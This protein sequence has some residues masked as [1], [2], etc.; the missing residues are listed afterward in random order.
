[1]SAADNQLI[2]MLSTLASLSL[3]GRSLVGRSLVGRSLVG[4]SLGLGLLVARLV[5]RRAAAERPDLFLGA[6]LPARVLA[7]VEVEVLL[8][9]SDR[10][11]VLV[12]LLVHEPEVPPC[13]SV[14]RV[15]RGRLL[16]LG[17]RL[18]D[19]VRVLLGLPAVHHREV[20]V[21]ARVVGPPLERL[22]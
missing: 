7:L 20:E 16:V 22:S 19:H 4:R 18:R 10:L 3:L 2:R 21:D 15:E 17:D 13:V 5:A 14:A 12:I 9:C 6:L 1:M 8:E 11:V